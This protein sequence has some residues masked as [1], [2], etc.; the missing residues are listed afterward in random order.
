MMNNMELIVYNL[1]S[2]I[3]CYLP[4]YIKRI[5]Y[6]I[7]VLIIDTPL[8][9]VPIVDAIVDEITDQFYI[10]LDAFKNIINAA[11]LDIQE[12]RVH[13]IP[14]DVSVSEWLQSII[15]EED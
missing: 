12:G 4:K 8:I 1:I 2:S 13:K 14:D 10:E 7:T 9:K 15:D 5:L 3:W 11:L 6:R